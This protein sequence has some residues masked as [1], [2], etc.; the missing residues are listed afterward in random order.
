M[1][2]ELACRGQQLALRMVQFWRAPI[3]I[4]VSP[5]APG[6]TQSP[7]PAAAKLCPLM[8]ALS[9]CPPAFYHSPRLALFC[10]CC[11][12][13]RRPVNP[14]WPG[15]RM[16][17]RRRRRRVSGSVSEASI[18]FG[19]RC[20]R[21]CLLWRGGQSAERRTQNRSHSI[22]RCG[23]YSS[24]SPVLCASVSVHRAW[25]AS[26]EKPSSIWDPF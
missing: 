6:D 21:H 15:V 11:S 10:C 16:C 1:G 20:R 2:F 19:C 17:R 8:V 7:K 22:H 3:C 25:A 26:L 18:Q 23:F 14:H 5:N 9:G 13:V 12:P 24:T 4:Q